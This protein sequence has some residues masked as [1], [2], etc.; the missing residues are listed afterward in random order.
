MIYGLLDYFKRDETLTKLAYGLMADAQRGG[1]MFNRKRKVLHLIT[2]GLP[3]EATDDPECVA[4]G[5]GAAPIK[6]CALGIG[7][8]CVPLLCRPSPQLVELI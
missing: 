1:E 7:E 2:L 5:F 4:F 6:L 8:F 3:S